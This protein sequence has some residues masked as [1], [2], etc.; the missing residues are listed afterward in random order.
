MSWIKDEHTQ[1][2]IKRTAAK[3]NVANEDVERVLISMFD[4]IEAG[5]NADFTV[6]RV[7]GFGAWK[8]KRKIKN[9]RYNK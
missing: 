9:P 7:M 6:M 3:N 8:D 4:S 5:M 1:E 2:L